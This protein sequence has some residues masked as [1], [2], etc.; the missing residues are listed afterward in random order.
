MKPYNC[1]KYSCKVNIFNNLD[2]L[3][4]TYLSVLKSEQLSS[5]RFALKE[6]KIQ[7]QNLSA[8]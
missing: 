1:C 8:T 3:I 4:M 2:V 6:Y 7:P 5:E